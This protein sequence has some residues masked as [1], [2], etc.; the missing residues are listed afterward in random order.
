MPIYSKFQFEKHSQ[1]D[2]NSFLHYVI[3]HLNQDT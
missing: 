3:G 2:L 1:T